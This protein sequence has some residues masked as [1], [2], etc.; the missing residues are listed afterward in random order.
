MAT[1][2][3]HS[4]IYASGDAGVYASQDGGKT[5]KMVYSKLL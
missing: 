5:F 4:S 3:P 2:G 1:G